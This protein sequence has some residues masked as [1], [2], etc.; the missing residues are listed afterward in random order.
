M[1]ESTG[2]DRASRAAAGAASRAA[3]GAGGQDA[4]N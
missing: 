4:N 1:R 2:R 3:A